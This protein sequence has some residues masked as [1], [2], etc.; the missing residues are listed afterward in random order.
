MYAVRKIDGGRALGRLMRRL[1]QFVE[2]EGVTQWNI[3]LVRSAYSDINLF[4]DSLSRTYLQR[5]VLFHPRF[6]VIQVTLMAS[7]ICLSIKHV[8]SFCLGDVTGLCVRYFNCNIR[9]AS[10]YLTRSFTGTHLCERLLLSTEI[11][12]PRSRI[13]IDGI[14][15]E[16]GARSRNSLSSC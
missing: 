3:A 12:A 2:T 7:S 1:E 13:V 9:C 15:F 5:R 14:V 16:L 6:F 10:V 8:L 11:P 4:E